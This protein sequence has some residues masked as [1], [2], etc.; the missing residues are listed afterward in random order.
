MDEV[1]ALEQQLSAARAKAQAAC[2]HDYVPEN[3]FTVMRKCTRC[4]HA[5]YN[6]DY[7]MAGN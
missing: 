1:R 5:S 2:K 4:K 6:P 3:R 7:D